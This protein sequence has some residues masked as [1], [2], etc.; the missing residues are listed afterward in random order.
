M[1]FRLCRM[2]M[3]KIGLIK[4]IQD[5]KKVVF[6]AKTIDVE[7]IGK[8]LDDIARKVDLMDVSVKEESYNDDW[9]R[10]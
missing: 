7:Y 5:T 1:Y 6:E 8:V 4:Y 9:S 2:N 10:L 3:N